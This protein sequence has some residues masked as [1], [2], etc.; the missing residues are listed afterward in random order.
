[1]GI[2]D[3]FFPF[4]LYPH[5]QHLVTTTAYALTKRP[6]SGVLFC[7]FVDKEE[8]DLQLEQTLFVYFFF[9]GNK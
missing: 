2:T 1:M 5:P 9:F 3:W 7:S 8:R 6:I 4:L